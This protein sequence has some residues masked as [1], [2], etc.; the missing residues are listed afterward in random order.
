MTV[1]SRNRPQRNINFCQK[2]TSDALNVVFLD[3]DFHNSDYFFIGTETIC[4]YDITNWLI[5]IYNFARIDFLIVRLS[6][7]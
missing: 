4:I 2:C 7:V 3:I 5:S 6:I 1:L